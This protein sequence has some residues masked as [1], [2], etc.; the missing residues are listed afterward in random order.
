MAYAHN[1]LP[2]ERYCSVQFNLHVHVNATISDFG[3]YDV[4]NVVLRQLQWS[5]LVAIPCGGCGI[6]AT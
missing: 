2:A 3:T 1:A 5:G 6:Y 4:L